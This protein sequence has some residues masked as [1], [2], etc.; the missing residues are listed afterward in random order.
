MSVMD[1][2]LVRAELISTDDSGK[3][4]VL[5]ARG[6]DGEEYG[7][8]TG[9]L[10]VQ[11]FGHS[12]H[13]PKGAHGLILVIGGNPD[14]AV[15]LGFEHPDHRPTNL[16]EGE[17]KLY[18]AFG[19]FI[20]FEDGTLTIN[21]GGCQLVMTNGEIQLIGV[22]KLGSAS[23]SRP[24]SAQGTVDTGGFADTSNPL[25]KVWGI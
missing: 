15:L 23:A 25:S 21:A 9:V 8:K 13:V 12:A 3:T 11:S 16:A 18:D 22:V 19:Q 10:R 4:Q 17:H 1:T 24:V 7:G 2:Y 14:M 5:K 6:R 20:H